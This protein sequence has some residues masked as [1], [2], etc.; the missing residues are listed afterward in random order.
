[1]K[2]ERQPLLAFLSGPA[3]ILFVLSVL[4][5]LVGFYLTIDKELFPAGS[6]PL[7]VLLLPS[8]ALAATAFFVGCVILKVFRVRIVKSTSQEKPQKTEEIQNENH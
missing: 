7:I 2:E 4:L 5:M 3:Q 6:Y 8:I 1:M